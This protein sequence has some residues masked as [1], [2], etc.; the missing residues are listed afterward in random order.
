MDRKTKIITKTFTIVASTRDLKGFAPL[1]EDDD[2]GMTMHMDRGYDYESV[3]L[4]L[5]ASGIK[6]RIQSKGVRDKPLAE[7]QIK[8]NQKLAS[9]RCRVEH[10]F[11]AM[12]T[13]FG[14][15]IIRTIGK[16]RARVR[17]ILRTL[18]YTIKRASF[19]MG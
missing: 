13:C 5:Q 17:N 3:K 14:P 18:S 4:V 7:D 12:H 1:L 6:P 11:G 19:L 15:A 10:A 9:F 2:S 16:E 8:L